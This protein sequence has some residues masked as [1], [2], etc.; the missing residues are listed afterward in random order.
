M[1]LIPEENLLE[2]NMTLYV[3]K[4]FISELLLDLVIRNEGGVIINAEQA[5]LVFSVMFSLLK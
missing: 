2:P 4:T 5:K 1:L 3:T